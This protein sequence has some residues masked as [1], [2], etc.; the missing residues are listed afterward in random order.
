MISLKTADLPPKIDHPF[1]INT[2]SKKFSKAP[3]PQNCWNV[4]SPSLLQGGI[5]TMMTKCFNTANSQ[6]L[7]LNNENSKNF[8]SS[9]FICLGVL[10]APNAQEIL[11]FK[12]KTYEVKKLSQLFLLWYAMTLSVSFRW[13]T[14]L[15]MSFFLFVCLCHTQYLW[16]CTSSDHNFWYLCVI[17]WYLQEFFSFF[18]NFFLGC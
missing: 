2:P 10:K 11:L 3:L 14:H 15:H 7:F 8:F 5:E 16:N 1:S 4:F 9:C 17:W 13:S 6:I 18:Q 12:Y